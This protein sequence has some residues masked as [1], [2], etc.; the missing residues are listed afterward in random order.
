MRSFGND[1]FVKKK[2][3]VDVET[4]SFG[5]IRFGNYH[6]KPSWG[7]PEKQ[8]RVVHEQL[9][10]HGARCWERAGLSHTEEAWRPQS[11]WGVLLLMGS[12]YRGWGTSAEPRP[13]VGKPE[14]SLVPAW[15]PRR[16]THPLMTTGR[17]GESLA[18]RN[19][20]SSLHSILVI[21]PSLFIGV[22]N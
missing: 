6:P 20:F 8:R 5:G 14:S 10:K 21:M 13:G 12:P 7:H 3:K 9:D 11:R 4:F 19:L 17:N 22:P 16:C 18:L 15:H 2:K 1:V